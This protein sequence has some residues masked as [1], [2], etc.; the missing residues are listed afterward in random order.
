MKTQRKNRVFGVLLVLA[1]AIC[2]FATM[3]PI[4]LADEPPVAELYEEGEVPQEAIAEQSS[5]IAE[6]PAPVLYNDETGPETISEEFL[7]LMPVAIDEPQPELY[8][9]EAELDAIA[10]D[11]PQPELVAEQEQ[12]AKNA[13][14]TWSWVVIIGGSIVVL[15]LIAAA[16]VNG[17]RKKA[18]N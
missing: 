7:E 4:A 6:E 2:V 14:P 15:A 1:I 11:E 5:E 10:A 16:V 8:E 3:T 18:T 9:E 12:T 17:K 13:L